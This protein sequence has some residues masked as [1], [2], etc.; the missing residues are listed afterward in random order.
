ME[1]VIGLI[2]LLVLAGVVL[3]AAARRRQADESVGLLS[4]ETRS[5]DRG[6][7][8]GD[9]D[10]TGRSFER[11]ALGT[12]AEGGSSSLVKLKSMSPAPYEPPDAEA[13]GVS[14][15]MFLNR[16]IVGTF[17]FGLAGF[18]AS[19]I[20][21]LWPGLSGGFGSELNL[22]LVD[23][24][25]KQIGDGNG[26]LYL[27][28]GKMWVTEYPTGALDAA[29]SVYSPD[30]LAGMEVGLI[31]LFQ[32]CPHLGCRVPNCAT[33]QWFE[34]PCHGSQYNRVG[35]KR[36][37]PAPRGMDRFAMSVSDSGEFLVNTGQIIPGPLIGTDTTKQSAEGPNCIGSSDH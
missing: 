13:L 23:D 3:F 31:A 20:A 17:A 12:E 37:G 2:A 30:E 10:L 26:F 14:R 21:F 16:A 36:G 33:S 35:E 11:A 5:R 32:K 6:A 7:A 27:A 25:K 18:G 34:C 28:E 8:E 9:A 29:A 1:I 24:V 15:R 4:R 22:G 19:C